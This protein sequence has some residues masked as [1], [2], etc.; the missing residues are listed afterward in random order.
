MDVQCIFS[1][2]TKSSNQLGDTPGSKFLPFSGS[3]G[4]PI[5]APDMALYKAAMSGECDAVIALLAAG[6][7]VDS[8][9]D[10]SWTPLFVASYYGHLNVVKVGDFGVVVWLCTRLCC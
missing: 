2:D 1:Q 10:D 7:K 4:D 3:S 5:E 6:A 8:V 9:G